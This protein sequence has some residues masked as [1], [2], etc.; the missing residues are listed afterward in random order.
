LYYTWLV[1]LLGF[2][3]RIDSGNHRIHLWAKVWRPNEK[4]RATGV[5][6]KHIFAIDFY[7]AGHA[8]TVSCEINYA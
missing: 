1:A 6:S 3:R 5:D 4:N 7:F 8:H 2:L